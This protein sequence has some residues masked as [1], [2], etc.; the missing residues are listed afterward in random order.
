MFRTRRVELNDIRVGRT[1]AIKVFILIIHCKLTPVPLYSIYNIY[2]T[3]K[4]AHL[5]S[6]YTM[7]LLNNQEK[8]EVQLRSKG[9]AP[10]NPPILSFN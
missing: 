10:P 2:N 7:T 5:H 3:Y 1:S 8:G 9:D 4:Q 6:H